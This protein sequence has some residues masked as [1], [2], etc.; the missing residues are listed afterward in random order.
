MITAPTGSGKPDCFLWAPQSSFPGTGRAAGC[1]SCHVSPLKALNNDVQ[2]N[3]L[4]PLRELQACFK[5]AG[6]FP[7]SKC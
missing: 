7:E 5:E 6:E 3:L 2:R 1:E 4:R